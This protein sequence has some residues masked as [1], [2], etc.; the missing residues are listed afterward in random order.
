ME[1]RSI[2][3]ITQEVRLK[4]M[5]RPAPSFICGFEWHKSD[6]ATIHPNT[7]TSDLATCS[8][9]ITSHFINHFAIASIYSQLNYLLS[10]RSLFT[11]ISRRLAKDEAAGLQVTI[12]HSGRIELP[13]NS[14]DVFNIDDL[15]RLVPLVMSAYE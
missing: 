9:S 3:V 10:I 11:T 6:G 13:Q 8:I 2:L 5:E 4:K 1:R 12:N 14:V 15:R 7:I